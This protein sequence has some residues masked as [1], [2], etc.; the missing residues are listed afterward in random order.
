ME[1][2]QQPTDRGR[3]RSDKLE[4]RL[5][6]LEAQLKELKENHR[7]DLRGLRKSLEPQ[8]RELKKNH[9]TGLKRLKMSLHGV[10]TYYAR[11]RRLIEQR[12]LVLEAGRDGMETGASVG[13]ESREPGSSSVA[14]RSAHPRQLT[15]PI[16]AESLDAGERLT[17][18]VECDMPGVPADRDETAEVPVEPRTPSSIQLPQREPVRSDTEKSAQTQPG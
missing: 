15:D 8:L 17:R 1:S 5:D 4:A 16:P 18:V 6:K 10:R 3:E 7:T 14:A 11:Q 12:L 2:A 13:D 9:G